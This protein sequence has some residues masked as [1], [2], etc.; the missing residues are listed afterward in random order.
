MEL[1][2]RILPGKT[3]LDCFDT[4]IAKQFIG[5]ECYFTT[6]SS[7]FKNLNDL[8]KATLTNISEDYDACYGSDEIGIHKWDYA[9]FIIPCEWVKEP[10]KRYRPYKNTEELFN[11]VCSSVGDVIKVRVKGEL[12]PY[13]MLVNGCSDKTVFLGI[14]SYSMEYLFEALEVYAY[15][16]SEWRPLGIEE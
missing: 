9:P 10:E 4:E 16:T 6:V 7:R 1:D 3:Y 14:S 11:D 2:S 15:G 12:V 8:R 13:T 5:K